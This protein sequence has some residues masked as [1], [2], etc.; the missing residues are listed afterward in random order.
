M[1]QAQINVC[2]HIQYTLATEQFFYCNTI[3]KDKQTFPLG[4]LAMMLSHPKLHKRKE[5]RSF[6]GYLVTCTYCHASVLICKQ[7]LLGDI[8]SPCKGTWGCRSANG[9]GTIPLQVGGLDVGVSWCIPGQAFD[10]KYDINVSGK[11]LEKNAPVLNKTPINQWP[12]AQ[13]KDHVW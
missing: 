3:I 8:N 5:R 6:P 13:Q 2:R 4:V 11:Y 1:Q 12:D 7:V 9:E 10:C